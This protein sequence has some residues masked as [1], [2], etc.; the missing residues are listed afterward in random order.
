VAQ[1]LL[2]NA[3]DATDYEAAR[4]EVRALGL[5]PDA[6]AHRRPA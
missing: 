4:Q 1:L 6:I 2:S 3:A 5:D